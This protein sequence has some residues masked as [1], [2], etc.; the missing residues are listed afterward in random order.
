MIVKSVWNN[1]DKITAEWFNFLG[2][3]ILLGTLIIL[4]VYEVLYVKNNNPGFIYLQSSIVITTGFSS[5][6]LIIYIFK[7]CYILSRK[8]FPPGKSKLLW[9]FMMFEAICLCLFFTGFILM[10]TITLSSVLH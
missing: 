10:I 9:I 8:L 5:L 2:W 7:K 4:S 1:W 3:M 6:L